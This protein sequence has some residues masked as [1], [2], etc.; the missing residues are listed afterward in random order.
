V[1]SSLLTLPYELCGARPLLVPGKLAQ[2]T[3]SCRVLG[4]GRSK[5][6]AFSSSV[7]PEVHSAIRR[8]YFLYQTRLAKIPGLR[9]RCAQVGSLFVTPLAEFDCKFKFVIRWSLGS[10]D[11]PGR[12]YG[13]TLLAVYLE[14]GSFARPGCIV[15]QTSC[16]G[17]AYC[18]TAVR[19]AH[20]DPMLTVQY[21]INQLRKRCI[22]TQLIL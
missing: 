6:D 21:A 16:Q 22:T 15:Y 20:L 5:A 17:R 8:T 18:E 1:R 7:N 13:I 11:E 19:P 2:A 14:N 4:N 12:R 3:R 10:K 9:H